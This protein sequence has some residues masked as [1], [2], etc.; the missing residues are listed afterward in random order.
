MSTAHQAPPPRNGLSEPLDRVGE[1]ERA[2]ERWI[3]LLGEAAENAKQNL[4]ECLVVVQLVIAARD[5]L[6]VSKAFEELQQNPALFAREVAVSE[7]SGLERRD[8][9]GSHGEPTQVA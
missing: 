2:A 5:Q 3:E 1:M 8:L 4:A 9:S 7:N 6:R